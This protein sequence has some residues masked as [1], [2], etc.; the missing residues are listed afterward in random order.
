MEL[1]VDLGTKRG[2]SD[3]AVAQHPQC[4]PF[5]VGGEPR[6][7]PMSYDTDFR[8]DLDRVFDAL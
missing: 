5:W 4:H 3:A 8:I 7:V 1:L 6:P 2:L